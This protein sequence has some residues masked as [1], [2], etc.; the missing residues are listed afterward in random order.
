MNIIFI[1]QVV[2]RLS[3]NS[4]RNQRRK[5]YR[6]KIVKHFAQKQKHIMLLR[7]ISKVYYLTS[8]ERACKDTSFLAS[9]TIFAAYDFSNPSFL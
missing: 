1:G 2:C 3:V 7:L 8:R 4:K 5:I 6:C 9:E